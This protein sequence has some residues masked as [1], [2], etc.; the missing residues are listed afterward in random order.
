MEEIKRKHQE[1]K[2]DEILSSS[3]DETILKL[4]QINH[5]LNEKVFKLQIEN[6]NLRSKLTMIESCIEIFNECLNKCKK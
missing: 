2:K 1:S 3:D 6:M 5:E 4:K